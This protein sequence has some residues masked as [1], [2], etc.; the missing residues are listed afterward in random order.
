MEIPKL[1]IDAA[2][3]LLKS[4]GFFITEHHQMQSK[5]I[6]KAMI[7]NFTSIQTHSDLAGRDRFTTGRRK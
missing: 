5:L 4:G 7:E 3:R 2:A 1:F 6:A